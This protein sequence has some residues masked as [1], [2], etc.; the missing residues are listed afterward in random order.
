MDRWIISAS[1]NLIKYVRREMD[2]YKLYTV[3]P[4]LLNFLE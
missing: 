3:V 2:S 1:Q 4:P